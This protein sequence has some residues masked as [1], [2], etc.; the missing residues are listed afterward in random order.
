MLLTLVAPG[1]SSDSVSSGGAPPQHS[2]ASLKHHPYRW[3]LSGTTTCA[4]FFGGQTRRSKHA[5]MWQWSRD[6]GSDN[7]YGDL[8]QIDG[9]R[10]A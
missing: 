10:T 5:L 4:R 3:C 8:D 1:M 9:N 6:G 2:A 7:G